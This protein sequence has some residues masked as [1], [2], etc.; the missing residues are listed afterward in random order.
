MEFALTAN[1]NTDERRASYRH[2]AQA[3]R[4]PRQGGAGYRGN[5]PDAAAR[6]GADEKKKLEKWTKMF[7]VLHSPGPK[8]ERPGAASSNLAARTPRVLAF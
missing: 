4:L 3:E 7:R 8:E 2:K 1:V 6:R 5:L